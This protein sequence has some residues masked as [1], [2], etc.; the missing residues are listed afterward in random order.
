[1]NKTSLKEQHLYGI[2]IFCDIAY[3]FTLILY[4]F[5]ASLEYLNN[6]KNITEPKI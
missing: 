3:F 5:K 4:Q 2:Q 1:M 6:S